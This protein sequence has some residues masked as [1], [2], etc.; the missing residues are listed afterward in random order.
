MPDSPQTVALL[1]YFA[2]E[3]T[4]TRPEVAERI[5]GKTVG[6]AAGVHHRDHLLGEHEKI[7]PWPKLDPARR[8]NRRCQF[9][10]GNPLQKDFH[11]CG[12]IRRTDDLVCTRHVGK[13]WTPAE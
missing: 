6:F 9:P 2:Q 7:G 5:L 11:L 10:I 1:A 3:A 13:T 12:G 4:V 8:K